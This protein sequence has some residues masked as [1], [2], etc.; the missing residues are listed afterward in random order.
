M[1]IGIMVLRVIGAVLLTQ[2]AL[3]SNP[4]DPLFDHQTVTYD[5]VYSPVTVGALFHHAA[6]TT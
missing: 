1:E 5:A 4:I 2:V 6:H 3:G